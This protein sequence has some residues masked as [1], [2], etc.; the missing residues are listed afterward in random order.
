[1]LEGR[2][3]I[4]MALVPHSWWHAKVFHGPNFGAQCLCKLRRIAKKSSAFDN[5]RNRAEG[6]KSLLDNYLTDSIH[7]KC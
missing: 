4:G 6:Q 7:V 2:G 3:I 1:M 5:V